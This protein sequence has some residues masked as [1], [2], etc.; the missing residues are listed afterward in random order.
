M[1]EASAATAAVQARLCC[2]QCFFWQGL[3]QYQARWHCEQHIILVPSDWQW[4]QRWV[5][6][7]GAAA[8]LPLPLLPLLLPVLPLA[9]LVVLVGVELLVLLGAPAAE[10]SA[11]GVPSDAASDAA[12]DASDAA[13][14]PSAVFGG[15]GLTRLRSC[16][17]P[18]QQHHRYMYL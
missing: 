11:G 14:A 8:P 10:A 4:K 5:S 17:V 7:G 15:M 9:F 12:S 2:F 6:S 18:P 3:P 13:R 16:T 1:L